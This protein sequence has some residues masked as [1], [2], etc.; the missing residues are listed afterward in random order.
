MGKDGHP[1]GYGARHCEEIKKKKRKEKRSVESAWFS[2]DKIK[3]KLKHDS[4]IM[5]LKGWMDLQNIHD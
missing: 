2:N 4:R 3:F 5:E 1:R